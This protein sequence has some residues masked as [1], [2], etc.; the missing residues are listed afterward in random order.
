M[1][2]FSPV[3]AAVVGAV[4]VSAIVTSPVAAQSSLEK[5]FVSP[6]ASARPHTWWHWINGNIT[7]EGITADLQAMARIGIGGAQIFNVEV[8]VPAGKTP[9]MSPQWREAVVHAAKEAKRFGVELCLHNCA[10]WSSSGGP[11]ITPEYSMQILTWSETRITGGRRITETLKEP[12]KRAGYY[13]DIC[14]LAFKVPPAGDTFRI[15]DAR[16]KAAFDRGPS[17]LP[18]NDR[19][20]PG[21]GDAPPGVTIT[22]TDVV[23]LPAAANGAVTWDAPPGEWVLM[24]MGHTTTGKDNH[25]APESGRGLECDKLS[26]AAMDWHW[27]K[28]IAPILKDMGTE[29]AGKVLNNSLIDSYEVGSQNWTP[30]F[31]EEFRKRRGYDVLPWL[32]VVTGRVVGSA[33]RSE[34]FLWDFRRTIADLLAENYVGRFRELCHKNGMQF[35]IEPYGNGPF[36][37]LQIGAMGDIPMGEFW[38]G[39]GASET[40]K[41]AASAAHV[42]GRSVVGAESFT[43]DERTGRFLVEPY[44]VKALGDRMFTQGVNRYIFHRYAHQPWLNLSPGMTMGPW[45]MHLE[46]TQT[47]WDQGAD[48][49]RYIA[50]CQH[51]LQSGRFVADVLTFSGDDAPND[52]L[53]PTL[54]R[55]YDYDGCDRTILMKARVDKGEIVLPG[56]ARYRVLVLPDSPWMTPETAAKIAQLAKD[57]ATIVGRKPEKSPSLVGYPACDEKVRSLATGMK[58]VEP[59]RL[60]SVLGE[61]DVAIPTGTPFVW[62][63]RRTNDADIYFV[64]NQR[65]RNLSAIVSFRVKGKSPELW[66]PETGV[67][68]AAPIWN[69]AGERTDVSLH[70]GPAESVFVVFRKSANDRH[71]VKVVRE[72]GPAVAEAPRT[73]QI[74]SARYE[75][76]EGEGG[77]D[78]TEKVKA[79]VVSGETEIPA[80]NAAFG[81]PTVNRLKQLRIVYVLDGKRMEKIAA[82]NDTLILL[83]AGP[84]TDLPD[85]DIVGGRLLAYSPGTYAFTD[86]A[87]KISR[88]NAGVAKELPLLGEWRLSLPQRSGTTSNVI[89]PDGKLTAWN[90]SADPNVRYFSGTATYETAF[91]VPNDWTG[92]ENAV[93]LDLGRVKNFAEVTLNGKALPLL[94]KAPFRLNVSEH[95]QPG[96]NTLTV[97]VTNLWPNRLI[98]DEQLPAEASF[99]P[100]SAI[101]AWPDWIVN[102]TPRPKTER[103]TFTTWQFWKKDDKPLDSGIIG[104]VRLLAVP[105]LPLGGS[106]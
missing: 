18:L 34:R 54:P 37:N 95:L 70:L 102:G 36:D 86:A 60:A 79:M 24:R 39:G 94:W 74:V 88:Q 14:V 30:A 66:R 80:T 52:L 58:L 72:S 91:T 47:W 101:K 42:T 103:T 64:S 89:F 85:F 12:P 105:T 56:G 99:N 1:I 45:G 76:V 62:I 28:G 11:W 33:E 8:G 21:G 81:D 87:G 25:P 27:E 4:S 84:D 92:K 97:R 55:G 51:L 73:I 90:E 83:E 53:R 93:I 65:Y 100:G 59:S 43:A 19:W 35:S 69:S 63:H 2:R 20:T 3:L 82:E 13:R 32:P 26:R 44:G 16:S 71:L 75:P 48:W 31:R 96:R 22:P 10:G 77:A 15:P 98:G 57:G 9:F 23:V 68:E 7:R 49:M 5:G 46:R 29:L 40:I 106:Q 41:I 78:V 38:I 6:P 104:T 17:G 67:I 50:R 61:P